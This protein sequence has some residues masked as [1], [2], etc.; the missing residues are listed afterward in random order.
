[1]KEKPTEGSTRIQTK[2]NNWIKELENIN[3]VSDSYKNTLKN[4]MK[5][6]EDSIDEMVKDAPEFY[7]KIKAVSPENRESLLTIAT[8]MKEVIKHLAVNINE[9]EV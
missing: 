9:V 7:Q 5:K 6:F 4:S 1:M 2:L 8:F 3:S